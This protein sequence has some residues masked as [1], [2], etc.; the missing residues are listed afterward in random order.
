A[1][2]ELDRALAGAHANLE[3]LLR[4]R[5]V[6]KHADPDLTGA[7]HVTRQRATGRFDLA[8]G[9]ALRLHRLQPI[10][11]E[12]QILATGRKAMDAALMRLAELGFGRLQHDEYLFCSLPPLRSLAARTTGF[13]LGQA[14]ILR[15]GVVLHDLALEDPD[16]DTAGAVSGERRGDAVVDIGAQRMQRHATLAIPLHA[17]NFSAAETTRAIDADALRAEPDR[18]LHGAL[19]GA[20]ERHAT[21]KLLRDRFG[22]QGGIELRLPDLDDVDDDVAVGQ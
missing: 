7:L 15:H 12:R 5:H 14:L 19:H 21:L 3:R 18:R 16:L 4:N 9:D 13:R 2:P 10:L 11:A 22:N 8:R 20:A 6:R 1:D 17:G